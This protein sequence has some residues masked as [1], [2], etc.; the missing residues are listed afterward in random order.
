MVEAR[1][2]KALCRVG[3]CVDASVA[4]QCDDDNLPVDSRELSNGGCP[5]SRLGVCDEQLLRDVRSGYGV[6]GQELTS[7]QDED[8]RGERG[9]YPVGEEDAVCLD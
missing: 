3:E 9:A 6:A 8:P 4:E 1:G 2:E 5:Y 7:G